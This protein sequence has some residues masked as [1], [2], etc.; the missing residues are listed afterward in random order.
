MGDAPAR[1][2]E[3]S[4]AVRVEGLRAVATPAAERMRSATVRARY[5]AGTI[6]TRQVP[7]YVDE[8][9]VDP[10]RNTKTYAS[11]TVEV[12]DP[13]WAGVPFTLRS[14]KALAADSAE[15]TIHFRSLPRCLLDQ[16]PGVEPKVLKVG[17]TD[18]LRAA[19]HYAQRPGTNSRT[20]QLEAR[21]TTPRFTAY[22]HL[23]LEMLNSDAH[24]PPFRGSCS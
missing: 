20:Q 19:I 12:D 16:W 24:Q 18:P 13:R 8:P 23:I 4:R 1:A 7:S 2:H 10:S 3:L 21:S 5:T 11:L 15:I 9:G 22:A 6:E 17:L 14:G